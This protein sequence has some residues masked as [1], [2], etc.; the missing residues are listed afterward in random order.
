[1]QIRQI[2]PNGETWTMDI[3]PASK[4]ERQS[5]VSNYRCQSMSLTAENDFFLATST[6]SQVPVQVP[7]LGMQVQVPVPENCT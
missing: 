1:M 6:F 4:N 3:K 5:L 2:V 7:V